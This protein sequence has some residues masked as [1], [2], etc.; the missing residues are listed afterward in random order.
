MAEFQRTATRAVLG[1]ASL[2]NAR[3]LVASS[4]ATE[5]T[6][7]IFAPGRARLATSPSGTASPGSAITMASLLVAL[8]AALAAGVADVE[9]NEFGGKC[10]QP[11]CLARRK[12]PL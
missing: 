4:G 3:R 1:N 11:I 8:C 12:P 6:P 5:V 10:R 7:V 2:S 9:G